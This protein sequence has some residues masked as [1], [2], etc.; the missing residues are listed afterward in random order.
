MLGTSQLANR[1]PTATAGRWRIAE[2]GRIRHDGALLNTL[3]PQTMLET[4]ILHYQ[5]LIFLLK[6]ANLS[7]ELSFP[8]HVLRH[9]E[10]DLL[11]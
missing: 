11:G 5:T 2:E 8:F 7:G 3:P 10:V 1:A 4:Q 9:G 6:T